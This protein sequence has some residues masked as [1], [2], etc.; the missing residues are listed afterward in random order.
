VTAKLGVE[1]LGEDQVNY[2]WYGD[3]GSL[4]N[5]SATNVSL[6]I[7]AVQTLTP[8]WKL[9]YGVK[10]TSLDDEIDDSPIGQDDTYTVVN[11]G[12]AYSF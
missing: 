11:F 10:T 12:A 9:L 5:D 3:K 1:Y 2:S 8:S 7:S 4:D 6:G